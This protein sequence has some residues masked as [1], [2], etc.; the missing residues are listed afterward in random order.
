MAK[1]PFAAALDAATEA[2]VIKS[3]V[4]QCSYGFFFLVARRS[5]A[6]RAPFIHFSGERKT[7]GAHGDVARLSR[8]AAPDAARGA[9][10]V[11]G[12]RGTIKRA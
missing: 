6:V 3:E 4:R 7:G 1:M 10:R 8:V 11:A 12:Y 2:V 5:A 9:E